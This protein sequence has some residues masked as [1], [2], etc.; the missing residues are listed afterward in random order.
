MIIH[1]VSDNVSEVHQN[2]D[3]NLSHNWNKIRDTFLKLQQHLKPSKASWQKL[4][5]RKFRLV[6]QICC[7]RNAHAEKGKPLKRKS[8]KGHAI[9]IMMEK[10]LPFQWSFLQL[11]SEPFSWQRFFLASAVVTMLTD[12]K[13]WLWIFAHTIGRDL[14]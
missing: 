5:W 8:K 9:R 2:P 3:Q 6:R 11:L 10:S 13:R 4:K 14:K 12:V 7:L 1:A